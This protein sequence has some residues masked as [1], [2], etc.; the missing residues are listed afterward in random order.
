MIICYKNILSL[1]DFFLHLSTLLQILKYYYHHILLYTLFHLLFQ[2][3]RLH[4]Y[5]IL[6]HSLFFHL[7]ILLHLIFLFHNIL[8]L[9][10]FLVHLNILIKFYL[11]YHNILLFFHFLR[12][13]YIYTFENYSSIFIFLSFSIYFSI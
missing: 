5:Y 8:F 3:Q 13:L 10:H 6:S 9:F 7:N 11:L 4:L 1:F 12:L 2:K